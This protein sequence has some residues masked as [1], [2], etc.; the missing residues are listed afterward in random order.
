MRIHFIRHAESANNKLLYFNK[1]L[2]GRVPDPPLSSLGQRQAQALGEFLKENRD[3][4][5]FDRIY[6]SPFLRTLQTAAAFTDLYPDTPKIVWPG[7]H[8]YGGCI[9]INPVTKE[10]S[11]HTG[12]TRAEIQAQFPEYRID[13]S[14]T[15]E[16]WYFLS[17]YE[18][19]DTAMA[20]AHHVRKTMIAQFGDTDENIAFV[21]HW[22][23]HILFSN[24]ILELDGSTHSRA[25]ISN[26]GMSVFEYAQDIWANSPTYW[27]TLASINRCEWLVDDLQRDWSTRPQ[28]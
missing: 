25:A 17:G 8:E 1:P 26:T 16:G 19:Y 15:D 3:D 5:P 22:D 14:V 10:R 11:A 7:I 18:P 2:E 23:F 21:S 6:I 27:W 9:H 4:F 24:A 13:E 20:R 28:T 12:M